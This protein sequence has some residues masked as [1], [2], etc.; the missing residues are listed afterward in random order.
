[1]LLKW[2]I[3]ED[4]WLIFSFGD[5]LAILISRQWPEEAEKLLSG[6]LCVSALVRNSNF[7]ILP[8][9]LLS[10]M[11]EKWR[12]VGFAYLHPK[13]VHVDAVLDHEPPKLD[14]ANLSYPK[15]ATESFYGW[16]AMI[17]QTARTC[18]NN[19]TYG[20][21]RIHSTRDP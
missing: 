5:D 17:P 9:L 16:L 19:E 1:V 3:D 7:C 13:Y 4:E 18:G 14:I 21:Q 11:P 15:H 10:V 8:L 2:V 20:S 6:E 12:R